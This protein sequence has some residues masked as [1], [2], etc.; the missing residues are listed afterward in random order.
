MNPVAA[1]PMRAPATAVTVADARRRWAAEFRRAGLDSPELDA[2]LLV[3]H[4]LGLDH[5]ALAAAAA[6]PLDSAEQSAIAALADRRL[7]HEPVAR[8]VGVKEFWS[9]DIHVDAATL[10]PRPETETVV[11]AALA[12]I[13]ARDGR[14]H[15]GRTDGGRTR[16]LRIADL[17][18][19]SGAIL[20]A[21][22]TELPNAFG[23]GS[24]VSLQALALARA[25]ARSLGLNRAGFVACNTTA[26]LRGPFDLIV[27]N[28]PYI[29][30]DGIAALPAEVR[31]FDP[32]LALD[33]GA[34]GL[35]CYRAIAAAV[36]ALLVPGGAVIVELGAG[37]ADAV[38]GLFAGTGLAPSPPRPD[39][40]G[41]QRVLTAWKRHEG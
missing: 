9:L 40:S 4:A 29:A 14:T 3:G 33:G 20:L 37:Q 6:R 21:L 15:D 38:A 8:I 26:A 36:P 28:P 12:A 7:G 5:A 11:E 32:R 1:T 16:A 2:R 27:S 10:V 39:L 24:D 31:L 13:D 41:V 34:D 22:L 19:G 18:T 30:S 25:N 17:G 23:V 35:D